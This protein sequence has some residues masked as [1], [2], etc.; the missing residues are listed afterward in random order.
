MI[1]VIDHGDGIPADDHVRMTER[2][3][4]GDA[5]RSQSGSGLGL[6]LAKAIAHAH[7]GR[8]E[9]ADTPGGGLT[10]RLSVPVART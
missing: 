4:R 7:G 2:F 8:L 9:L 1:S 6:A 10:V 5:A 3:A